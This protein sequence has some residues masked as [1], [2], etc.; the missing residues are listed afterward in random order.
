MPTRLIFT[1]VAVIAGTAC[2]S[3][4]VSRTIG[5][6]CDEISECDERCLSGDDFP[7]GFCSVSCDTGSD[8]PND[9]D[10]VDREGGV[11]MFSCSESSETACEFL[12]LGWRCESQDER[13]GDEVTV[14]IG[15]F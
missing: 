15:D 1:I 10:C 4:D 9:S 11:C 8:C 13:N 14:C 5:A 3:S 12:G 2:G 7:G 6:R